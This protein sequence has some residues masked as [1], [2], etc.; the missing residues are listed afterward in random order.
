MIG[1]LGS[2]AFLGYAGAFG[3]ATV[4]CGLGLRRAVRI[5]DRDTRRGLL[6]LL[7]AGCGWA[8]LQFGFVV[9]GDATVDYALYV[10]SL[11]IGLTTV[12]AW[13]YFCSAYTG[14]TFH[15]DASYRRAAV[16]VYLG[17]VALKLTNPVHGLYFRTTFVAAPFPHLAVSHGLI[18][19]LVTGASYALAAVGFFMLYE[20]FLEAEYDTRPLAALVAVTG[21][22]VLADVVGFASPLLLDM[23]YEPLGVAVLAVG[24]LYVFDDRFLAVQLTSD[25]DEPVVYLTADGRVREFN[26]GARRLF[27]ALSDG[28]GDPVDAVVPEVARRLDAEGS[29]LERGERGETRYYLVSDTTFSLGQTDVGRLIAFTDVTES[30]RKRRE[31]DRHNEQLGEFVVAIRHEL[32]NTLQ[33][34]DGWVRTAGTALEDG[35]VDRAREALATAAETSD[36]MGG[37]VQDFADLAAHGRTV[38]ETEPV[39]VDET[40]RDAYRSVETDGLELAVADERSLEADPLRLREMLRNAVEFSA[41][42]D[43]TTLWV[44]PH[45]DGFVVEDDGG[46]HGRPDELLEYGNAVPDSDRG[47]LLPYLRTLARAHGWTARVDPDYDDGV[48]VVVEGVAVPAT[49]EGSAPDGRTVRERAA[50]GGTP[51]G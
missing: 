6:A 34:I 50:D 22:P 42:N 16:V 8:A 21:L 19:W 14:R 43:A 12:G 4:A 45:D 11:V 7:A 20:L 44:R 29:I 17:V 38:D 27:P 2:L 32:L 51:D 28:V 24:V 35:D 46:S 41:G 1:L 9:V 26:E 18:H 47:R 31:I 37:L 48:R 40:A 10:A 25:L 30:E 5:E 23:N 49:D 13:L 36:R 33:L 3:A 39:R 15:R